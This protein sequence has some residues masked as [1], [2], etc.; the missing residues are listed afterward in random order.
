MVFHHFG[1]NPNQP[2]IHLYKS[3]SKLIQVL[4]VLEAIRHSFQ[5]IANQIL[6]YLIVK[7]RLTSFNSTILNVNSK[8][9]N[10][11]VQL[12]NFLYQEFQ[13]QRLFYLHIP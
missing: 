2:S 8:D 4:I 13:E 9:Y 10:I 5:L 7:I 1:I 11:S 12:R 3:Q 6:A